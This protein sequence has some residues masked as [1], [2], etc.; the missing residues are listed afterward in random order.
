MVVDGVDHEPDFEEEE[1]DI[2]ADEDFE[3]ALD[4]RY[5]SMEELK[6]RGREAFSSARERGRERVYEAAARSKVRAAEALDSARTR[7]DDRFAYS[8]EYLRTRDVD[9]MGED[10]ID[11]VRR[12][13]LLS[14]GIALGAG[15][16]V[17]KA[18]NVGLPGRRR[19]RSSGLGGQ[20]GRAIASSLATMV[21]AKVSQSLAGADFDLEPEPEPEPEPVRRR[22]PRKRRPAQ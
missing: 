17:G 7:L 12:R 2:E 21:A 8:A 6:A 15:Y 5:S 20:L 11:A 3:E 9:R 19:K 22:A 13:P 18:L 10:F 16:L 14:A 4:G 1:F